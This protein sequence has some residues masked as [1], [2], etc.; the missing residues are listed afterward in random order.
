MFVCGTTKFSGQ[1]GYST[2]ALR[3]DVCWRRRMFF[4]FW[5]CVSLNSRRGGRKCKRP[6]RSAVSSAAEQIC[7]PGASTGKKKIVAKSLLSL[8]SPPTP[9]SQPALV[10]D[11]CLVS[12]SFLLSVESA[13]LAHR[14]ASLFSLPRTSLPR[15]PA[16]I[17][18]RTK[19]HIFAVW[20]YELNSRSCR[21]HCKRTEW[22]KTTNKNTCFLCV[23]ISIIFSPSFLRV[24]FVC[25]AIPIFFQ[26]LFKIDYGSLYFGPL[27][28]L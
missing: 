28:F 14:L 15:L 1:R 25:T 4:L 26:V 8:F 21:R 16:P 13:S 2:T 27:I 10:M 19:K 18:T 24:C 12:T 9:P 17:E 5:I 11:S 3:H 23:T 7:R 6:T 20:W 22:K